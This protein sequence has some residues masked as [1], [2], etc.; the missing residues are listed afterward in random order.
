MCGDINKRRKTYMPCWGQ[1]QRLPNMQMR[2]TVSI[3]SGFLGGE[4]VNSILGY[5]AV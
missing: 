3:I 5:G 4:Y 1:Q 2:V